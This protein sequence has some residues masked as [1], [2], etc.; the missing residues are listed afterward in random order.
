MNDYFIANKINILTGLIVFS[1]K[2]GLENKTIIFQ[3]LLEFDFN[4]KFRSGDWKKLSVRDI[5]ISDIKDLFS[6]GI[7]ESE[8]KDQII[9]LVG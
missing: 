9:K 3:K 8:L 5:I 6:K 7:I 2:S 4:Y 1:T